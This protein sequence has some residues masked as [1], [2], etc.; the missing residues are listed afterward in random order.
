MGNILGENYTRADGTSMAAPH[1]AGLAALIMSKNPDF[2]NEDVRQ[3]LHV[4]SEKSTES[5]F[6]YFVGYGRMDALKAVSQSKVL[7]AKIISPNS[8]KSYTG[9]IPVMGYAKGMAFQIHT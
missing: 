3:I 9:K 6:F 5:N 1:V 8:G 2:S 7:E 4:T